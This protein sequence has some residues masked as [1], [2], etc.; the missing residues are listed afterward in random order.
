MAVTTNLRDT[1]ANSESLAGA[2]TVTKRID[3]SDYNMVATDILQLFDLEN[4]QRIMIKLNVIT[5]QGAT[6]TADLI[7]TESTPVTIMTAANLE[8]AGLIVAPVTIW[9]ISEDCIVTLVA[10]HTTDAAVIDVSV[11]MLDQ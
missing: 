8:T 11:T 2:N 5:G 1:T 9:T 7:T 6:C 10:D 3:F 4:G